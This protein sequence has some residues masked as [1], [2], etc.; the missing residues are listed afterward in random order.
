MNANLRA[1]LYAGPNDGMIVPV[2][3]AMLDIGHLHVQSLAP[4]P[5]ALDDD[6]DSPRTFPIIRYDLI[7][8]RHT[9][10]LFMLSQHADDECQR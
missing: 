9:R 4:D 6:E 10:P 1:E 8:Q 2:T 5:L 7:G 3:Q